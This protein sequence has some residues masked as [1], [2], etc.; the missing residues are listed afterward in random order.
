MS[1][2]VHTDSSAGHPWS[3]MSGGGLGTKQMF[4]A[5]DARR[6]ALEAGVHLNEANAR[7]LVA[8][9]GHD[10]D[11]L[12]AQARRPGFKPIRLGTTVSLAFKAKSREILSHNVIAKIEGTGA[13]DEA[14]VYTA[15]W[16]HVGTNPAI[17]GDNIFNGAVDNATGT[18]ALIELADA[19]AALSS[20]PRRTVYFVATTAEEKGLLGSEYLSRH[21]MIPLANIV[22]VLNMDAL[23]PFGSYHGMAVPAL[24]SSEVEDVLADAARRL[25]RVLLPDD[26]PQAGAY[27]RSDHYPFAEKGVPAVFAVG[28]PTDADLAA[29]TTISG[30]FTWYMQGGYHKPADE[31]DA[32]TW[33]M[34]GIEGDVR[35]YFEMDYRLAQDTRF[36]N[37][38]YGNQFRALRDA[39]RAP[40]T[41]GGTAGAAS[42]AATG[43]P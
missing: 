17:K 22:A 26:Q 28:N 39:M 24:G 30:R 13:P 10:F 40:A 1:L 29:D 9:A 23:F 37:W 33:K 14:V 38:R 32:A 34:D 25:D 41:A 6:E 3:V 43:S 36:P 31:Y 42:G 11:D 35:V 15:H 7:A 18:A 8:R 4:L 2:T 20:R 21:P 19:F 16:D 5:E 12:V 27:Y